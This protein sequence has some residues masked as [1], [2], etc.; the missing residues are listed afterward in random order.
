MFV[1]SAVKWQLKR[2]R[3][4]SS[5][6]IFTM[7]LG[8]LLVAALFVRSELTLA[9][10]LPPADRRT[11]NP[12]SILLKNQKWNQDMDE[13][14]RRKAQGGMAET[15]AGAV[16]GGLLLGPFGMSGKHL[17]AANTDFHWKNLYSASIWTVNFLSAV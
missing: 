8:L 11:S 17:K 13:A 6:E 14:S 4:T 12:S 15:A 1:S 3:S 16:L 10:L 9:F 7:V 2:Y 5:L